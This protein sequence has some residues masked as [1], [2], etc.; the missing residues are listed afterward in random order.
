LWLCL[1]WSAFDASRGGL[2]DTFREGLD[3]AFRKGLDD[4]FRE[5]LDDAFLGLDFG[6][7][8]HSSPLWVWLWV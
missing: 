4:A 5:G 7:A 1:S 2:D 6:I 8:L 3:D